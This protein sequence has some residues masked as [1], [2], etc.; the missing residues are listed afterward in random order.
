[1]D[2][3]YEDTKALQAKTVERMENAKNEHDK[4][5]ILNEMLESMLYQVNSR[6]PKEEF[7]NID[8]T[9]PIY[10]YRL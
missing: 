10:V 1:M 6:I 9:H 2:A 3:M 7:K 4:A 5:L 8:N